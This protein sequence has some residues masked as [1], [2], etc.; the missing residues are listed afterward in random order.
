M[1]RLILCVACAL[2]W[3]CAPDLK[4]DECTIGEVQTCS[5]GAR[6]GLRACGFAQ[7]WAP[8]VCV[9]EDSGTD[10]PGIDATPVRPLDV[11]LTAD[12]A[13]ASLDGEQLDAAADTPADV[14]DAVVSADV[15]PDTSSVVLDAT[16][17][18]AVDIARDAPV[19]VFVD[20][21]AVDAAPDMPADVRVSDA[22]ADVAV[23]A[24][25]DA[26][27]YP[28]MACMG[29]CLDPRVSPTTCDAAPNLGSYCG[30]TQ[31]R[32]PTCAPTAYRTVA[33]RTGLVTEWF[34]GRAVECST[35][36]ANVSVRLSLTVPSGVFYMLYVRNACRSTPDGGVVLGY[37]N[38]FTRPTAQVELT[39]PAR[40]AVDDS[41]DYVIEVQHF[42]GNSCA[43]WT[44]TVEA[45]GSNATDC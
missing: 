39:V 16:R 1:W 22:A 35:C 33:M 9:A 24:C 42:G 17:D 32:A 25:I 28:R 12:V 26:G 3:A 37:A 38:T 45:R 34:R 19:E 13:D 20:D 11:P 14:L 2:V 15:S 27:E 23:D 18:L 40:A 10:A 4:L 30:D 8:C 21:I 41:F 36:G 43:P 29:V 44:L 31:C 5:C 7:R 6:A